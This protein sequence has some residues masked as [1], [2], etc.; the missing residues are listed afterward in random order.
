MNTLHYITHAIAY[1]VAWFACITLAARGHA[2]ISSLIVIAC[3]LLQLYW[4]YHTGRTLRGLGLLLAI[5]VSISTL[6]DSA[7][8]Y[9]G[10]VIYSANPFSPYFT[11]PWMI[12]IW[13][14]FTVVL[15]ATLNSLFDRL[16][17]LGFLSC[18][19]FAVA[20]RIG[21]SLGAAFFPHGSNIT[22]LFIGIIWS[23]TLPFCVYC[24]QKI[25]DNN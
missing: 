1:Y 15:Y 9:K 17:L 18:A 2:W 24:Y 22:S 8:V 14:S 21:G 5:I 7:L 3:V 20:F 16:L 10:I 19:G 13:V 4:Q 23:I 12:T 25:K 6:I 11:S